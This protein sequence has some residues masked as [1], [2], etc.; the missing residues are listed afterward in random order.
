VHIVVALALA[1]AAPRMGTHAPDFAHVRTANAHLQQTIDQAAVQSPT[2]AALLARVDL[3]DV[4]VYFEY[5]QQL[6]R[7]AR[8]HLHFVTSAGG[9]RYLRVGLPARLPRHELIAS[10]AHELRHAIEIGEH[11][12]VRCERT[13]KTLYSRIGDECATGEFETRDAIKAGEAVRAEILAP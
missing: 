4:V 11:W 7:R 2:F 10:I 3:T 8:G 12:D 1:L 13:M 5:V 9:H 6:P